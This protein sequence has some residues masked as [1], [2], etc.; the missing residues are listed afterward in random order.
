MNNNNIT[1]SNINDMVWKRT[2]KE[3]L[4]I[5]KSFDSKIAKSKSDAKKALEKPY[6]KLDLEIS[7]KQGFIKDIMGGTGNVND[8]IY[9]IVTGG[10]TNSADIQNCLNN[11]S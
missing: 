10:F 4:S 9:L 7:T 8:P 2:N 11:K 6:R 5:I 1:L 3:Y